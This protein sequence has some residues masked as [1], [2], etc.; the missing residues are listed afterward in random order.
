MISRPVRRGLTLC[1]L[2]AA[3]LPPNAASADP[4]PPGPEPSPTAMPGRVPVP[5]SVPVPSKP[6]RPDSSARKDL[7][8]PGV[9][10]PSF[11]RWPLDAPDQALPPVV[12]P[13]SAADDAVEPLAP[14]SALQ[15]PVEFVPPGEAGPAAKECT[16]S[17]GPHQREVEKWLKLK[18]D[19]RQS[20]A[21]CGA[22]RKFQ[23]AQGIRPASGY[24]GPVTWSRMQQLSAAAR[25]A[26]NGGCPARAHRVACVDLSRQLM[27]VQHGKKRLFGPVPIRSGRAGH[28]TRTGWHRVY[29]RHKNHVSSLYD[30]PMPYSQFFSGG[31]AFHAIY[32]PLYNP[33]GS[34]GCVN[35]RFSDARRLWDVLRSGDR[36]FVWGRRPGS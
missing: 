36:V 7:L 30:V 13:P 23:T 27:W 20:P 1:L 26:A 2:L 22:I 9:P 32:A 6:V 35:M 34:H 33:P 24:A 18:A 16:R 21:D 19:G 4:H 11:P 17:T 25:S 29:W 15:S 3:V 5:V 28:R 12:R 10:L 8:V 14:P 31:Q